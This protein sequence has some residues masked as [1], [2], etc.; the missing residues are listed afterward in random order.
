MKHPD[1]KKYIILLTAGTIGIILAWIIIFGLRSGSRRLSASG[2]GPIVIGENS[3]QEN[4]LTDE[5]VESPASPAEETTVP[6]ENSEESKELLEKLTS[7][8]GM[9]PGPDTGY[10]FVG[11]SRFVNMNSVCGI[12]KTDNLFMVAKVGEGY[13]WFNETALQQ[14]KR[15]ISSSLF[16]KWKL[17]ICLGINDLG[18]C[19]KYVKKYESLKDD[20]D[21]VLVSVNPVE[22]YGNLSN[23]G[24]DKFNSALKTLSLPYIDTF[25]LLLTTGY[26]TADGLHYKEDTTKKIYNG[27]LSGLEDISPGTLKPLSDGILSDAALSKKNSIQNDII[28]QNKYVKKESNPESIMDD[29]MLEEFLKTLDESGQDAVSATESL[30]TATGTESTEAATEEVQPSEE[31][32]SGTDNAEENNADQEEEQ[33]NEEEQREEE[34]REEE[35]RRAEEERQEEERRREEEERRREEEERAAEEQEE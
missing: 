11:D 7:V 10:I 16:N 17:I 8:E 22:H 23:E 24:I 30:E 2:N 6:V 19:E 27:I 15:I 1:F 28:A 3:S 9:S 26:S 31:E 4:T 25:N 12:S 20:Y 29:A 34:L 5:A 32:N 21:I 14:I 13:S 33:R 18:N 35:E